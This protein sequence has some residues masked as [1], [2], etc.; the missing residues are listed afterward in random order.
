[1]QTQSILRLSFAVILL[2]MLASCKSN[3]Q[4]RYIPKDAAVV[5]VADGKSLSSKLSWDE[6]KQNL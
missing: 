6:V 4:G 2:A 3:K 1:M 5:I